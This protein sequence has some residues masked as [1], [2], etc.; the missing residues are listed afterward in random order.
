MQHSVGFGPEWWEVR[1]VNN[2]PDCLQF[3]VYIFTDL[4]LQYTGRVPAVYGRSGEDVIC[5]GILDQSYSVSKTVLFCNSVLYPITITPLYVYPICILCPSTIQTLPY[6][7]PLYG[8]VYAVLSEEF[9]EGR[10][11]SGK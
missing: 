10:P 7:I 5:F 3:L 6:I 1:Q 2:L 4:L 11:E 9:L 8:I